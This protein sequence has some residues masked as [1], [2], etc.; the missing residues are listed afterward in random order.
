MSLIFYFSEQLQANGTAPLDKGRK[1]TVTSQ[2]AD[3]PG[4]PGD[5]DADDKNADD[6]EEKAIQALEVNI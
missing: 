6:L 3:V 5:K 4:I 2:G 1:R